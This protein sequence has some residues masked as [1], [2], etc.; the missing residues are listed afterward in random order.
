[1]MKLSDEAIICLD[2]L[3]IELDPVVSFLNQKIRDR[4]ISGQIDIQRIA[5]LNSAYEAFLDASNK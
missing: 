1:M 2:K 4:S 3:L 5:R